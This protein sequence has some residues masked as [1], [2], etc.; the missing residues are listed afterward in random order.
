MAGLVEET[1]AELHGSTLRSASLMDSTDLGF[2][3]STIHTTFADFPATTVQ[4]VLTR[5]DSSLT[6]DA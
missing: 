3:S 2:D 1:A 4:E 5:V 6:H